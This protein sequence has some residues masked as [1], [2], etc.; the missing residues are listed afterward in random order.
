[1]FP[2][3][4]SSITVRVASTHD[5]SLLV[6]PEQQTARGRPSATEDGQDVA[7]DG[8]LIV[9]DDV[10]VE[11][12]LLDTIHELDDETGA[13]IGEVI[14]T[15]LEET[16]GRLGAV[17][18]ALQYAYGHGLVYRPEETTLRWIVGDGSE[19]RPEGLAHMRCPESQLEAGL[20][21]APDADS[22]T[23]VEHWERDRDG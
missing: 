9:G 23:A 19:G 2:S 7:T 16:G 4:S 20:Q 17:C 5:K 13:P 6:P 15:V 22:S 21:S 12:V 8:G 18:D 11:T 1:M 14:E 10:D 3:P